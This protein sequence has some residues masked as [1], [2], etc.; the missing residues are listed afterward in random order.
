MQDLSSLWAQSLST[1]ASKI[2][3]FYTVPLQCQAFGCGYFERKRGS[4]GA[5]KASAA[6][7]VGGG[8]GGLVATLRLLLCLSCPALVLFDIPTHTHT[9]ALVF[10]WCALRFRRSQRRF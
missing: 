5:V 8:S 9:H 6:P 1:R 7:A 3:A 10:G 2:P 4:G